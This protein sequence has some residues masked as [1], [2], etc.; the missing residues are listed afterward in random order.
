MFGLRSSRAWKTALLTSPDTNSVVLSGY[1]GDYAT[2]S[3]QLA[4]AESAVAET[5][6]P[7]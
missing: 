7:A 4:E 2:S 6:M 1:F 3:P 5:L